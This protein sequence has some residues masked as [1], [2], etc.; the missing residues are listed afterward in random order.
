[1]HFLPLA[2]SSKRG[3]RCLCNRVEDGKQLGLNLLGKLVEELDRGNGTALI[4]GYVPLE[5]V[6]QPGFRHS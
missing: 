4:V 3:W 6:N 1:M 5:E 2:P